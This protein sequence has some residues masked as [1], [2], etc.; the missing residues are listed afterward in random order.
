MNHEFLSILM[1]RSPPHSTRSEGAPLLL[2]CRFG[3]CSPGP[4][5]R[6]TCF[7]VYD[8]IY[9]AVRPV[10]LRTHGSRANMSKHGH[11]NHVHRSPGQRDVACMHVTNSARVLLPTC[12]EAKNAMDHLSGFNVAGRLH[13]QL[14]DLHNKLKRAK[15]SLLEYERSL[16]HPLRWDPRQ[17]DCQLQGPF[18]V[19][20]ELSG[21]GPVQTLLGI[22]AVVLCNSRLAGLRC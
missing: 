15:S 12:V 11:T 8:D 20:H 17:V 18:I 16:V 14:S 9:D 13:P 4:E 22:H 3:G 21:T 6:G 1:A 5:T 7:V 2:P 10:L 19:W